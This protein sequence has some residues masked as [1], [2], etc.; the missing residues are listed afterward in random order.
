MPEN[1]IHILVTR[2]LSTNLMDEITDADLLIDIVPF[3]DTVPIQTI[4]V[5]QEIEQAYLLST[6]AVFT[7]MNAV[8]AVAT[9]QYDQQ[10]DWMIYCTGATTKKLAGEYFGEEKIAGTADSAA[11]LAELIIE[12]ADTDDVIFFCGNQRRDE[13]P[14]ILQQEGINVQEIIVYETIQLPVKITKN[15]HGV[16]FFSPS[17]VTSFFKNN[18]DAQEGILSDI[19]E[20]FSSDPE[21]E[22]CQINEK[23]QKLKDELE[24]QHSK[25]TVVEYNWK[26]AIYEYLTLSNNNNGC[27]KISDSLEAAKKVS[28]MVVYGKQQESGILQTFG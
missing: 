28:L 17:A 27:R 20:E 21:D 6:T 10:P 9:W 2:Q 24:K 12:S 19:E 7:S 5:Q 22:V 11:E 26:R 8:E 13:L 25:M 14:E 23:I 3:I 4:E 1:K 18:N 16:V 15:Y